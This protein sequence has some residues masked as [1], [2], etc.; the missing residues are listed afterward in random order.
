MTS[1]GFTAFIQADYRHMAEA[2]KLAGIVP[3]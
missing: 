3:K 2:A 1:A